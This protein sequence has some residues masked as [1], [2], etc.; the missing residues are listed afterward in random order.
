MTAEG[1][2]VAVDVLHVDLEV[3]GRLCAVNQY[4]H[5]VAVGYATDVFH[6]IYGA[7]HIAYMCHAYKACAL[8]EQLF[9]GLHIKGASIGHGYDA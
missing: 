5:A 8:V 4:G 6:R 2:E 1:K 9:K 7:Q 3:R